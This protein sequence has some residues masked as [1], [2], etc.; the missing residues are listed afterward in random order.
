MLPPPPFSDRCYRCDAPGFVPPVTRVH[1]GAWVRCEY[2]CP[3]CRH[4]WSAD[5]LAEY[6]GACYSGGTT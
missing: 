2:R 3:R 5:Y 1:V 4:G 6:L